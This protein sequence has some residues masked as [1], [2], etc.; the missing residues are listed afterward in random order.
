[1]EYYP[2]EFIYRDLSFERAAIFTPEGKMLD[3]MDG[4]PWCVPL[5]KINLSLLPGNWLVHIHPSSAPMSIDDLS[6]IIE[7]DMAGIRAS[8][9]YSLYSASKTPEALEHSN[10]FLMRQLEFA[11]SEMDKW[12]SEEEKD[13]EGESEDEEYMAWNNPI[14][15]WTVPETLEYE[16]KLACACKAAL[17]D[18]QIMRW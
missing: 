13:D 4:N 10:D 14:E 3:T 11:W 2:F 1:M 15:R 8:S 6:C 7:Y 16:R 17:L 5:R 18:L 12:E 9:D